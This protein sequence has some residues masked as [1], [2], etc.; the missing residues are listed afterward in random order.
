MA[1]SPDAPARV[2]APAPQVKTVRSN[3]SAA[4]VGWIRPWTRPACVIASTLIGCQVLAASSA[5]ESAVIALLPEGVSGARSSFL[6]GFA[7]GQDEA[8]ACG[9]DPVS[10]SWR[11]IGA[12][13]D[14]LMPT[15][16]ETALVVAPFAAD[17]RTF[18]RVAQE[19][20]LGVL[21]P[22]QRG[23]SLASLPELD[24][25]GRLHPVVPASRDDLAQLAEDTLKQGWKRVMVVVD[26]S[27]RSADQVEDFV[28][29]FEGLGGKVESFEPTLL[30]MINPDDQAALDRLFRDVA[31]KG[32]HAIVVAAAP[33][34][35]LA[36]RLASAQDQGALG[37]RPGARPWVWAVPPHRVRNL[38]ARSWDQLL[39]DQ[40]AHGP[41]W[42]SFQ[43]MFLEQRGKTPDLMAASG[44]DSARILTLATLAPAPASAE[45][46]RDPL[47]WM[48]ADQQPMSMCDAVQARLDGQPVRLKGAA[49]ALTGTPAQPPA[50]QAST[51]LML[52]K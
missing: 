14:A 36:D 30:Q 38:P 35:E 4:L 3:A 21:L 48:D 41:G 29:A 8:R 11:T 28:A 12:D 17:L 23:R 52:G 15:G 42:S 1:P 6:S 33:D 18:S 22:Y 2:S 25:E 9:I 13:S 45:G 39:L 49:S 32:P 5:P 40:P 27:D 47:G 50:G 26:P 44:F 24:P 46:T 31:W 19:R 43:T 16:S 10:V 37:V 51:R 7:L 20:R 34:G